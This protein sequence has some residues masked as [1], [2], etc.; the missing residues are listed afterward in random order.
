[1][2]Y[3]QKLVKLRNNENV[4][5]IS[6]LK[7][8]EEAP[9]SQDMVLLQITIDGQ[10]VSCKNLNFFSALLDLRR[11][12]E[13]NNI[14]IL[15]NGAAKN[16]YPSPMQLSMGTGRVAYKQFMGQQARMADVVDIFDC[17]ENLNFVE[18]EEQLKF[19]EEWLK[20]IKG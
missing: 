1:M 7:I 14:Q 12:L 4:L 2:D 3:E 20:S 8:Y 6:E 15:C 19:H 17:D 11:E 5:V 16:I 10:K 18:I 9:E 13:K